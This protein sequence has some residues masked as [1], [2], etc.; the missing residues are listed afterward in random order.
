MLSQLQQG[1][2]Q[3]QADHVVL[4]GHL[5][6]DC[7]IK[8]LRCI[9]AGGEETELRQYQ[10]DA[11]KKL[12]QGKKSRYMVWS[13]QDKCYRYFDKLGKSIDIKLS[14]EYRLKISEASSQRSKNKSHHDDLRSIPSPLERSHRFRLSASSTSEPLDGI[15]A[16]A[17]QAIWTFLL[18]LYRITNTRAT[19]ARHSSKVIF[20]LHASHKRRFSIGSFDE[21]NVEISPRNRPIIKS[22]LIC[23][24]SLVFFDAQ[25]EYMI[26]SKVLKNSSIARIEFKKIFKRVTKDHAKSQ[27]KMGIQLSCGLFAPEN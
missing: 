8:H 21:N 16:S 11:I 2:L 1:I 27:W 20:A 15:R 17:K 12:R 5:T 25:V 24:Y 14:T 23:T 9:F 19:S 7:D 10:V 6:R 3:N 26:F 18:C 13:R 4:T 22:A